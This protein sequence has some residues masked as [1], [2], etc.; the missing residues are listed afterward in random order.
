MQAKAR[1]VQL[2]IPEPLPDWPVCY[3]IQSLEQLRQF[4][5]DNAEQMGLEM[6]FGDSTFAETVAQYDE[7]YFQSRGLV[8]VFF[9]EGDGSTTHALAGVEA[10]EHSLSI[11]ISRNQPEV[12]ITVLAQWAAIIELDAQYL[13]L[14]PEVQFV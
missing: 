11:L 1:F 14:Q 13:E 3:S 9:G 7:A 4:T 5:A 10:G 12:V 6:S 2:G 8:L